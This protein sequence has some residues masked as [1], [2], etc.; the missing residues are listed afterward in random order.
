MPE[1]MQKKTEV[2]LCVAV[3]IRHGD[4]ILLNK[5]RNNRGAGSWAP[6]VGHM[7]FGE[8]PEQCAIREVREETGIEIANVKFRVITNDVFE[9][10][11]EHYITIWMEAD[12]VSGEPHVNAPD[13]ESDV[14][15]FNWDALPEP[16]F[17]SLQHVLDGKTYPSQ[18]TYDKVGAAVENPHP[19]RYTQ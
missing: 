5:R 2:L 1:S 9:A 3:L 8:S 16:L 6:I 17:L 4:R 13:E 15:W 11:H 10:E 14:Q 18:A 19:L 12:H 7:Q